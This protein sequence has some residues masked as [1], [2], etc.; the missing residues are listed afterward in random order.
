[1]SQNRW[2]SPLFSLIPYQKIIFTKKKL[3]LKVYITASTGRHVKCVKYSSFPWPL[4]VAAHDLMISFS[5]INKDQWQKNLLEYIH[6][7]L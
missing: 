5:M 3:K 1:M 4:V 2:H 7:G 6:H